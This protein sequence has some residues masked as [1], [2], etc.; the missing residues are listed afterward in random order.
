MRVSGLWLEARVPFNSTLLLQK[1][2]ITRLGELLPTLKTQPTGREDSSISAELAFQAQGLGSG[3][4]SDDAAPLRELSTLL[5][6]SH[7]EHFPW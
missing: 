7:D 4:T 2:R 6:L 5:P 1:G 3:C